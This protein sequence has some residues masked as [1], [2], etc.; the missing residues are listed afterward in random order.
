MGIELRCG[1]DNGKTSL[2]TDK[3]KG[4]P[5]VQIGFMDKI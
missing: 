2:N 3:T 5:C 1:R 4:I